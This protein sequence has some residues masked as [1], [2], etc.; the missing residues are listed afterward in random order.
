ME[1][2]FDVKM[3][4]RNMMAFLLRHSYCRVSGIFG[5]LV[6]LAA[7]IYLIAQWGNLGNQERFLIA[8]LASLFTIINPI[9]LCSRAKKQ[10][11][12]NPHY[13]QP[14]TYAM[15]EEGIITSQGEESVM[16]PWSSVQRVVSMKNQAAIYTSSVH[17]FLFPYDSMGENKEAIM[18]YI[19]E[20]IA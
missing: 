9:L 8:V 5:L 3:E 6:S 20:H 17:A 15:S 16:T 13:E 11:Q 7:L 4:P 12:N 19:K 2:T 1:Y 18:A 10:V 14:I